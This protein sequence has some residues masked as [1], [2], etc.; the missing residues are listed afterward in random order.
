MSTNETQDRA[1]AVQLCDW[2]GDGAGGAGGRGLV[3]E[4]GEP[5]TAAVLPPLPP[6]EPVWIGWRAYLAVILPPAN[7]GRGQLWQPRERVEP[8]DVSFE[9]RTGIPV[10]MRRCSTRRLR[11]APT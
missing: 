2:V 3:P 11:R 6:W 10:S 7:S 8:A 5:G 1:H 9:A 4:L